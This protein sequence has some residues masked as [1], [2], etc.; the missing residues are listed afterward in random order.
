MRKNHDCY[1]QHFVISILPTSQRDQSAF[2]YQHIT[3]TNQQI[4]ILPVPNE[5]KRL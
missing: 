5:N 1:N 4:S 2:S 3:L